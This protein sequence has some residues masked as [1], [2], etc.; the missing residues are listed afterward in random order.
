MDEALRRLER[1]AAQGGEEEVAALQRAMC[2]AGQHDS[3]GATLARARR[4]A[5]PW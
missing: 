3:D 1:E 2:R 5:S 4:A